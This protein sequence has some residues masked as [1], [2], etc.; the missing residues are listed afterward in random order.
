MQPSDFTVIHSYTRSQAI[1]DG[2]LIDVTSMAQEAG[3]RFPTVVSA[4]LYHNHFVPSA[5]SARSGQSIEGRLW[6][7]LMVFRTYATRTPGSRV[8]FPVEFVSGHASSGAPVRRTVRIL[9]IV[10][11]G[12]EGE[13]VITLMLPG[14]E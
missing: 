7:V 10:H 5:G 13:P 2:V 14:D 8:T 9:A 12:D 11:P 3:I 6:D 4:N 1:A